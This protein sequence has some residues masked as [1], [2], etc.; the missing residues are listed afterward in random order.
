MADA[1]SIEL[2]HT[3]LLGVVLRQLTRRLSAIEVA[4]QVTSGEPEGV[5]AL[6]EFRLVRNG[7]LGA[8]LSK[9]FTHRPARGR[10]STI[11]YAAS[12]DCET[13]RSIN[14]ASR[15]C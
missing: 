7:R 13:P 9:S 11:A 4:A 8:A 1:C 12:S 5:G 15:S 10:S 14:R 3:Q 2:D 6:L